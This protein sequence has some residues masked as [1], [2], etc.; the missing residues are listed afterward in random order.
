MPRSNPHGQ[1]GVPEAETNRNYQI[2][3]R[4]DSL[5]GA[6]LALQITRLWSVALGVLTVWSI[7]R[8]LLALLSRRLALVGAAAVAFLPQFLFLS[9]AASNDNATI[10]FA[11]LTLWRLIE[12]IRRAMMA[13]RR[14]CATLHS[15][16]RRSA[17]RSAAS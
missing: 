9:G 8:T 15:L 6:L 14:P 3:Y 13:V 2:H 5:R 10:A 1:I 16:A 4:T 7:Y 12:L 11:A 17:S